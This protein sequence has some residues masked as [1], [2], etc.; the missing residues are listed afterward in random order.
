M[1]S[2]L[3]IGT[4]LAGLFIGIF[5]GI[6]KLMQADNLWVGLT[7]TKLFGEERAESVITSFDSVFIQD[8]LD[9]LFYEVPFFVIVL[10]LGVIFLVISLFMKEH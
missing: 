9:F 3:G 6:S 8:K 1:F 7:L 10:G 2:K 4:L 5:S